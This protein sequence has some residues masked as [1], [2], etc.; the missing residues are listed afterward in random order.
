MKVSY[1]TAKFAREMN[2]IID[3][4]IGFLEGAQKGKTMFLR[5]LGE[6]ATEIMKEFVDSSARI[7]PESL[8]HVYEWYKNG[9]PEARLFDINYTVSNLGL[10]FKSS[11]SQSSSVKAGSKVP[12]YD[13]ARIM[14][15]G[16]PVTIRP[17]SSQVLVFD[18]DGET[19]FTKKEIRVENPGGVEVQGSLE[20]TLDMFMRQYF[21]QAFLY[22]SG[23]AKHFS[24][25]TMFK[26]N[27]R[28]GK[29]LGKPKGIETGYRWIVNVSKGAL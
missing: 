3:Y 17:V 16:I 10:S 9:S 14:E 7:N 8:H 27:M 2:N 18:V 24:N 12:F 5:N 25:G 4:S 11:L 1:N 15:E 6:N 26:N 23:I 29:S 20:R 13:K 28:S 19:V 22:N 21:T